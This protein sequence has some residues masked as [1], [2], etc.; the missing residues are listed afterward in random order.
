MT[1]GKGYIKKIIFTEKDLG[2]KGNR[3]QIVITK[4]GNIVKPHYHKKQTE[5]FC[6]LKTA[7]AILK[8]NKRSIRTKPGDIFICR[9]ENIH[10]V[11]NNTEENIETL[12]FKTNYEE[13]DTYWL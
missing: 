4:P 12:V 6:I 2:S 5:V 3:V 1:Q 10:S 11:V 9:P 13:N 7:G 8:I